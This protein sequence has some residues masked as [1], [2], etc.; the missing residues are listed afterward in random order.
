MFLEV[1]FNKPQSVDMGTR[2]YLFFRGNLRPWIVA[3]YNAA[4]TSLV[5]ESTFGA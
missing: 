1:K 4:K 2:I 5:L 3:G